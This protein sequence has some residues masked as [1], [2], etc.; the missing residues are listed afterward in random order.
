M[1]LQLDAAML[2]LEL[3]LRE[4]QSLE[5]MIGDPFCE[6]LGRCCAEYRL[7]IMTGGRKLLERIISDELDELDI[8]TI[9]GDIEAAGK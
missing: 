6:E 7:R 9:L 4:I 1:S 5:D 2:D 3:V 8:K